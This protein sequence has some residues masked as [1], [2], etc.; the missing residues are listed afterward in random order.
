MGMVFTP[1]QVTP[2]QLSPFAPLSD[3]EFFAFCGENRDW[4]IERKRTGE[5][6]VMPPAGGLSSSRNF[7][8]YTEFAVWARRDGT[9][10]MFDSSAGFHLPL[11]SI[12]SPDVSW[13][14]KSRLAQLSDD[15]KDRFLPLAPDFVLELMSRTDR[16]SDAQAKMDEYIE[17]GVQLGWLLQPK[18]RTVW[19]YRPDTDPEQLTDAKT[20]T[21][22]PVLVGFTLNLKPIW[23]PSF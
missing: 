5:I 7:N 23:S 1:Q 20:V 16:L 19:V 3:M 13:V 18:T 14:S 17:N 6:L 15:E 11:G 21:G 22:D 10:V 8:L 4:R 2:F 12:R 9:G